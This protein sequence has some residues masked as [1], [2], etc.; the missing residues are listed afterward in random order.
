MRSLVPLASTE[1]DYTSHDALQL[2]FAQF[3]L[4][5]PRLC[6]SLCGVVVT[7]KG[8]KKDSAKWK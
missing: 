1:E 6:W 5:G 8:Q 7:L 2:E 3:V 4:D